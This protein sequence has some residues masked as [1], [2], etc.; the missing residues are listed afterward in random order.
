MIE[1]DKGTLLRALLA[2][3]AVVA[4][5]IV[6]ADAQTRSIV[7]DNPPPKRICEVRSTIGTRLGNTVSCRTKAERDEARADGRETVDRVQMRK[8]LMCGVPGAGC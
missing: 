8:V 3:F 4:L 5:P 7:R 1:K 2:G 6:A